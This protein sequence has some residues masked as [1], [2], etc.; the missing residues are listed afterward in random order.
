MAGY[1]F[2]SSGDNQAQ[3]TDDTLYV[4]KWVHCVMKNIIQ[5]WNT[6]ISCGRQCIPPCTEYKYEW[7]QVASG[8]WPH[9]VYLKAFYNEFINE[10]FI[11]RDFNKVCF[12]YT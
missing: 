3:Q 9:P 10:T 6:V 12:G 7:S 4:L 5:Q 11:E 8:P 2:C 1:V